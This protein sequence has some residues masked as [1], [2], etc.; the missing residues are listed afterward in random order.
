MD[1]VLLAIRR[2]I[3]WWIRQSRSPD[4]HPTARRPTILMCLTQLKRS[5]SKVNRWFIFV[6][7]V[8]ADCCQSGAIAGRLPM[9]RVEIGWIIAI[10]LLLIELW[11][12][13]LR[14]ENFERT[15][16]WLETLACYEV[17][18]YNYENKMR[19]IEQRNCIMEIS[20][21]SQVDPVTKLYV[22]QPV[23]CFELKC[24]FKIELNNSEHDYNQ[25]L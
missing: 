19:S 8:F 3:C 9:K 7:K 2:W 1:G 13:S 16:W 6:Y 23:H 22:G 20:N 24:F 14:I 12:W 5:L 15:D 25:K 18:S 4:R 10:G 11:A 21:Q 17:H